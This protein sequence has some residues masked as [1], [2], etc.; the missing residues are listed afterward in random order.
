[1]KRKS[2]LLTLALLTLLSGCRAKEDVSS[3][4]EPLPIEV[5]QGKVTYYTQEKTLVNKAEAA[6][7]KEEPK[8]NLVPEATPLSKQNYSTAVLNASEF[9]FEKS[10]LQDFF[11]TANVTANGEYIKDIENKD[12][13][14]H[15]FSLTINGK[16]M[17]YAEF[18]DKNGGLVEQWNEKE[19]ADYK[20]KALYTSTELLGGVEQIYFD[21]LNFGTNIFCGMDEASIIVSNGEGETSSAD[22]NI[23]YYSDKAGNTLGLI[24]KE[25]DVYGTNNRYLTELYYFI[26]Q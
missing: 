12:F 23:V 15:G 13:C 21:Y 14:F 1:M 2:I 17:M 25:D 26:K 24:F 6:E 10:S 11:N 9:N 16:G 3:E 19:S 8:L 7:K 18:T 4:T 20:L 5:T 22:K